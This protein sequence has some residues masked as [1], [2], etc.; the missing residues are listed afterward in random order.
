MAKQKGLFKEKLKALRQEYQLLLPEKLKAIEASWKAAIPGDENKKSLLEMVHRETHTLAG[1]GTTFGFPNLSKVCSEIETFIISLGG[2]AGAIHPEQQA[3][4]ATLFERMFQAASESQEELVEA[5]VGDVTSGEN[6]GARLQSVFWLGLDKEL[7]QD[8]A[9]QLRFFGFRVTI[10]DSWA[11][12][13]EQL[14]NQIVD[15][16]IL[17]LSAPNGHLPEMGSVFAAFPSLPLNISKICIVPEETEL[18]GQLETLRAG[19]DFCLRKPLPLDQLLIQLDDLVPITFNGTYRLLIVDDDKQLSA[20]TATILRRAGM[21]VE[22]VNDPLNALDVFA[23]FKPDLILMDLYMPHCNGLE[24]S[25]LIRQDRRNQG[26]PIVYLTGETQINQ[27]LAALE[28][29][30]EDFLLKPVKYRY[31]YRSLMARI[32]RSHLQRTAFTHDSL[33]GLLNHSAFYEELTQLMKT[34]REKDEPL[35]LALLNLDHFHKVNAAHGHIIGDRVLRTLSILLR[36]GFGTRALISRFGG[37]EFAVALPG[38]DK[39]KAGLLF[40]RL[41]SHFSRLKHWNGARRFSVTLSGGLANLS[42]YREAEELIQSAGKGLYQAKSF[43]RN[44]VLAVESVVHQ[45]SD[46]TLRESLPISTFDPDVP[47]ILDEDLDNLDPE[48]VALSQLPPLA[49]QPF[50]APEPLAPSLPLPQGADPALLFIEDD[51][52][53]A[54]EDTVEKKE[55]KACSIVVVDDDRQ[56]L[57][58]ISSYLEGEGF[59]VHSAST[60]DEAFKLAVEQMPQI[61]LIDLLLF[62][63]IHGFELCKKVKEDSR[64]KGVKVILM[65]AVYKDYRYR[66]EG[67][68]AGGDAF[69]IKPL[70]FDELM[71]KIENL[72]P[73]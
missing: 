21:E 23:R 10:F 38:T 72:V 58:V 6:E 42:S 25:R 56:V 48:L 14:A 60:G 18:V 33:T 65:T 9:R 13:E 40:D 54:L 1:S 69:I 52:L 29:G 57:S 49:S 8:A 22:V 51:D 36:R 32:K 73:A 37:D 67:Q 63:G 17:D 3:V 7:A 19:A 15:I 41:S 71:E 59:L 39:E 66:L 28:S 68:D 61:M 62:P 43:G 47:L 4:A 20:N 34:V 16:L 27:K 45:E 46:P 70:N 26:I 2:S 30:A 44:R 64:L 50:S 53:E 35:T 11:K 12:L 5:E 55:R 31:L 24:L